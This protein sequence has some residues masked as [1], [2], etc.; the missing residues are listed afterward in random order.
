MAGGRQQFG[1]YQILEEL[2]AGGFATVF[3]ALDMTLDREV[4]LKI[5]HPPL[6][7]DRRFVQNFRQEAKTLAALRHPQ[8]ITIYEVGEVE[9]RLFI[10]MELA[11]GLSL[12]QSIAKRG[13]IAWDE[14][15]AVLKPVCEALDYAHG[16]K[17]V[18]R[19][20]KPANLLIDMQ[21]GA[22][23]TDFGFA[24]LMAE[25]SASMTM[26]GGIIGTPGYIAPEVWE[27]NAADTPVDIY[28]LGCIVYEM[29]TGDVLFKGQTPIQAM[30]AHDRGPQLPAVWPKDVPAGVTIVLSKALAR[31][32]DDRYTSAGTLWQALNELK[33]QA[34]TKPAAAVQADA[35]KRVAAPDTKEKDA[36]RAKVDPTAVAVSQPS[37]LSIIGMVLFA[38]AIAINIAGGQLVKV[39]QLPVSLDMIGTIL[40]GALFG[41]WI[42]AINGLLAN[43]IWTLL[44]YNEYALWFA[45]VAGVGG[46][47]A[48]FAGRLGLFQRTSPRWLSALNGGVFVFALT[49][50]VFMFINSTS[51]SKLVAQNGLVFLAALT[52]GMVI[53]LFA[54]RNAGYAGLAGLITGMATTIV[55]ASIVARL[56]GG[57][58]AIV[59]GELLVGKG[60]TV[61]PFDKMISF[62]I[63]YLIIQLLPQ[64]LLQRFPNM[65]AAAGVDIEH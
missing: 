21:R 8:I 5:L 51:G 54:L 29:L 20:L 14:M 18:H 27:N 19:D 22:L 10:A 57:E 50:F 28:A 52:L 25:N 59:V 53:G 43:A 49:L 12:T 4:A 47:L 60:R 34:Q 39:L 42:G 24:R 7:A 55:A 23:L 35:I 26:S 31:D 65:R 11:Y 37:D 30:R 17:V 40:I 62:M 56:F 13:R 16:R 2:G 38:L 41:P 1:K 15:L 64:R 44:G 45:P 9:G 46:L 58:T 48:G 33:R 36:E 32:P 3:K 63:A 6:L 61:E